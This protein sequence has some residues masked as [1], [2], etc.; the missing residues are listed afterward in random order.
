M[1]LKYLG[2]GGLLRGGACLL[3]RRLLDFALLA[4]L[5]LALALLAVFLLG[6][7]SCTFLDGVP[8]LQRD[9]KG[10]VGGQLQNV[11]GI[12]DANQILAGEALL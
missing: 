5:R 9:L 7:G 8:G 12:G 11:A 6:R 10:L 1:D 3:T 2:S 4:V